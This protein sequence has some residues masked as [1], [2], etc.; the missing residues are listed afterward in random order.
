MAQVRVK[1]QQEEWETQAAAAEERV[2]VAEAAARQ[3]HEE[4]REAVAERDQQVEALLAARAA[5]MKQTLHAQADRHQ[6]LAAG[7]VCVHVFVYACMCWRIC[8]SMRVSAC[9]IYLHMH[10]LSLS[11]S[12]PPSPAHTLTHPPTHGRITQEKLL[13]R[14]AELEQRLAEEESKGVVLRAA[15]DEMSD[16]VERVAGARLA[17]TQLTHRRL[18]DNQLT[19]GPPVR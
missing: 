7:A 9:Y 6:E 19:H 11:P 5:D 13:A 17:D 2:R 4:A 14:N 10:V 8:L 3:A 12:L 15:L 16:Y 1:T 18:A